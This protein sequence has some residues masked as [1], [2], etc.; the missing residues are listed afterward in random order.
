[1]TAF[2]IIAAVL[3]LAFSV[4]KWRG[5]V[6]HKIDYNALLDRRDRLNRKKARMAG[7]GK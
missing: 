7:K 5:N 4:R 2:I 3:V 1:M 6:S